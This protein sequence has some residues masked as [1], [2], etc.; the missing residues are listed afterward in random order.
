MYD[1]IIIGGGPAGL[2]AA[3]YAARKRL[4]ALL[5]SADIGG[6]I[7]STSGIENYLGYQ[8]IEGTDLISKFES[9]VK[10]YPI[11]QQ[12]GPSVTR[13][14]RSEAGIEVTMDSGKRYKSKDLV[15]AAGKRPRELNVPGEKQFTGRGVSYCATCDAPLFADKRVAV[16]GG[17]NSALEA[18]LDL[19]KIATHVDLVSIGPISGD[20]IL[21]EKLLAA[22]NV[23]CYLEHQTERVTGQDFVDGIEIRHIKSGKKEHLPVEGV[24]VEIGLIPNSEAMA[25]L[26]QLNE[27]GEIPVD[28]TGETSVPG[29]FAAGDVTSVPEK[30]IIVAAGDGAK[31]M[32]RAHRYLQH[33][34]E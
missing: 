26:T 6:Q 32:L 29:L 17:G 9:Q 1:V 23:S 16:V 4:N 12:I 22:S 28:C 18:A 2:A 31:A 20:L 8:F 13:V 14:R 30:Q 27:R 15:N 7:N 10:Q 11:E 21:K 34:A 25:G 24:F 19:V 3:V 5:L 33:M